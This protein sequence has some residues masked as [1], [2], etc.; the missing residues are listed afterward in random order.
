MH[1]QP[2]VNSP[3]NSLLKNSRVSDR[4]TEGDRSFKFNHSFDF[5]SSFIESPANKNITLSTLSSPSAQL[6]TIS[7]TTPQRTT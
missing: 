2:R 1:F 3:L 5:E 7:S 6:Q 4:S